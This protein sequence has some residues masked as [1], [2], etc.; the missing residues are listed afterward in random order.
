MAHWGMPDPAAVAGDEA[1][2]RR[3]FDV[4]LQLISRRLDLMLALPATSLQRMVL[5]QKVRAIGSTD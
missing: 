4:A 2:R 1:T 3:A 5:E